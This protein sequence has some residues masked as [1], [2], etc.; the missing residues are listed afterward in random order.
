[1]LWSAEAEPLGVGQLLSGE[2]LELIKAVQD[3]STG[4]RA[5]IAIHN[6]ARGAAF[7]GCRMKAY[8][9]EEEAIAD[10]GRLAEGMTYKNALAG[11][12][13][14]GGKA[15]IMQPEQIAD[16]KDFFKSFGREVARL[17][18][19]YITA[20]DVGTTPADMRAVHLVTSYVSGIPRARQF[21]GD[22]ARFTALGVLHSIEAACAP[23]LGR[24]SLD[25]LKVGI[26]G[27]GAVGSQ[28]CALLAACGADLWV[29]DVHPMRA[30]DAADRWNARIV[31]SGMLFQMDL[32]VLAP[33][34][35][36]GVLDAASIEGL[37][38]KIVAGAANNQLATIED[39]DRLHERGVWYL[40]DFLV[41]AGGIIAV[42]REYL[43]TG[44]EEIVRHEVR[45]IA[46]RVEELI[47]VVTKSDVAPARVALSWA[48]SLVRP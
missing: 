2:P 42:A 6:T 10:A 30:A 3:P 47:R 17:K 12:P 4:L 5:C 25:G 34:A 41:N 48:K 38:A 44:T 19:K 1:M 22:P 33:C 7:G 46:M 43:G 27:L 28:L 29:A 45:Q 13:F 16:R 9:S 14:G 39:G 21:G 18:G 40:P 35:V 32:D 8:A 20:E 15:V 31:S 11:L 37:N 26:Q 24:R 23:L 36:G